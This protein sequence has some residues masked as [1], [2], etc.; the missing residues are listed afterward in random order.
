M[1][2]RA[3]P[4]RLELLRT[5]R[6][7]QRVQKGVDLLRRKREALVSELFRLARQA[8]DLRSEVNDAARCAHQFLLESLAVHGEA[9][10]TPL[11]SR[12]RELH[13]EVEL[14]RLWGVTVARKLEA[15]QVRQTLEARDWAPGVTGVSAVASA[16]AYEHLV[17]KILE[18]APRE[19]LLRGLGEALSRTTRQLSVLEQRVMP[20][21]VSRR[22][23]VS[24]AL[25]EREREE[26]IRL[27]HLKRR[28]HSRRP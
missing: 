22:A 10:L 7:L 27:R 6:R 28:K 5:E 2:G 12:E 11:G 16:E 4:T 26:Q 1:S 3:A 19:L 25:D 8:V 24:Q 21:L 23:R 9:G 18:A 17:E 14:S 20:E 15:P 13:V